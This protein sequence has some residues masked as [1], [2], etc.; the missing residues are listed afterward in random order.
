MASGMRVDL[1]TAGFPCQDVSVAGQRKGLAGERSGLFWEIIRVAR[2]LRPGWLLL[3]NVPGLFSSHRGRDFG[4]VLTALDEL[5][6]GVAWTVLDAQYAG[7]AQRRERVFLVGRLGAPCPPEI[8]FEPQGVSGNPAPR[9]ETEAGITGDIA[10]CLNSGGNDG[11]F[12]TEPREHLVA[13]PLL[14]KPNSSHDESLETIVAHAL[15]SEGADASED[16]TGRGTPLAVVPI[17]EVGGGSS[18]RGD[19]PN[20]AG[21]G[22][23]GDPMFTLQS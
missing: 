18:S 5:G 7:L 17:L 1:I 10:A 20:G 4:I 2:G 11:G 19:G 14:G 22:E 8:L 12:R 16:G 21:I 3:E 23:E 15:R 9:R 13:H 6:Y